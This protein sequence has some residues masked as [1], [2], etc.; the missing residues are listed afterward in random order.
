M[1]L[2]FRN[3]G[4]DAYVAAAC[5]FSP[6]AFVTLQLE[7]LS[8]LLR[9]EEQ[10]AQS[11]RKF[12]EFADMLP[13]IVFETDTRGRLRCCLAVSVVPALRASSPTSLG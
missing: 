1:L 11:E 3:K 4:E 5:A 8:E 12:I 9:A 7:D 2:R 10:L 6:P 13:E